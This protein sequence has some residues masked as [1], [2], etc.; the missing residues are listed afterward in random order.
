MM[1]HDKA[2][3]DYAKRFTKKKGKSF[4]TQIEDSEDFTISL[5]SKCKFCEKDYGPNECW[6]LQVKCHYCHNIGH[7][8]KF[9]KKKSSPKTSP[10]KNLITCT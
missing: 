10:S 9:C 5:S 3:A 6:H 4:I 8:A 2:T 1:N 7:I